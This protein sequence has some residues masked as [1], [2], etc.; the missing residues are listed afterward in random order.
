MTT[1]R[2]LGGYAR[3]ALTVHRSPSEIAPV[4]RALRAAGRKIALVPTM[5]AGRVDLREPAAVR[6]R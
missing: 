5:G 3:G 2:T 6:P 4:T 1:A